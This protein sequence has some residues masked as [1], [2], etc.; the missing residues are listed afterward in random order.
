MTNLI[1]GQPSTSNLR[2]NS[3]TDIS[4]TTYRF[5]TKKTYDCRS[6]GCHASNYRHRMP[7]YCSS[8]MQL[9]KG[10]VLGSRSRKEPCVIS[11][12]VVDLRLG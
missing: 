3:C 2:V 8:S 1:G 4:Y 5:W 7:T 11:T 6:P 9:R 10:I 12:N